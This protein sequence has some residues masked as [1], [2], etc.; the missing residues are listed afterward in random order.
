M[1]DYLETLER[2]AP[3][4][5]DS[6]SSPRVVTRWLP[7]ESVAA[8][9]ASGVG[10][11]ASPAEANAP[12]TITASVESEDR[13]GDLVLAS[14]WDLRAYERNPVVL[15]AHQH[16]AP[17]I[18]R[19]LRT[20]VEGKSLLATV[21]FAPTPFAQEVRRL[22]EGGFLRGVS[23]GFRAIEVE[24]RVSHGTRRSL[25]FKRQELLEISAAPVPL[26][27][28]TLAGAQA[29]W[30]RTRSGGREQDDDVAEGA[31]AEIRRLWEQIALLTQ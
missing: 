3:E 27:P 30:A 23:V 26:H 13:A 10:A 14:G 22:Y 4:G 17:P 19:S 25:L 7:V 1:H 11:G 12:L 8:G 16:I 15:W 24:P 21:E 28:D 18:G 5:M 2:A 31:L 29:G 9:P 6:T 20:W